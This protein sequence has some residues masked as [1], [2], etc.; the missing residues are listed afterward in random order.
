MKRY[1][2]QQDGSII[3]MPKFACHYH[4]QAKDKKE[5]IAKL[6]QFAA[7]NIDNPP[8]LKA[9]NKA[10]QLITPHIDGGWNIDAGAIREDGTRTFALCSAYARKLSEI[11]DNTASF[12][13]YA[14]E[15]YQ[16][17]D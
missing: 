16:D 9:K 8:E 2:V 17:Q 10:W 1:I 15:E 6:A 12:A 7:R 11:D 5:A 13:Y 4:I 14:S 3:E